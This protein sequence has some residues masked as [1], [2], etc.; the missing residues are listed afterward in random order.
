LV[1]CFWEIL[2]NTPF[3]INKYRE[4]TIAFDYS[5]DSVL[6]SGFDI[7]F[8]S[9]GFLFTYFFLDHFVFVLTLNVFN[10]DNSISLIAKS[11]R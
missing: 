5:G 8:M 3:I 10:K 11:S 7:I 6:N 2:E 4:G 9:L 1:E